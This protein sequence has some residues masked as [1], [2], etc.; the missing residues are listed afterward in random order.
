MRINKETKSIKAEFIFPF[1][2]EILSKGKQ[3]RITVTGSS[4]YPF[5]RENID[6]VL[7]SK[8]SFADLEKG[9]IALI[10]RENGQYILH[11]VLLKKNNCFF[12]VGDAQQWI[13]GPLQEDQLVA[14]A[15]AIY[16]RDFKI[17]CTGGIWKIVSLT[18]LKLL[19]HREHLIASFKKLRKFM[20]CVTAYSTK[21]TRRRPFSE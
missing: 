21:L 17:D 18:W 16:R 15:S 11:R 8:V 10:K 20:K 1:I 19:P 7:L 6:S 9:N 14:V 5:L 2:E 13:E 4:M 12:I 3:V